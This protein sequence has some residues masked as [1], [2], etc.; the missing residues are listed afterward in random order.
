M[1]YLNRG[2]IREMMGDMNGA[3]EDWNHALRMGAEEANEY[4]K[5]CN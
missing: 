3:C 2:L 5:E 4:I 1:L